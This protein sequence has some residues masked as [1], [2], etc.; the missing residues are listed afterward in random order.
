M[1]FTSYRHFK[2]FRTKLLFCL[3]FGCLQISVIRIIY[4]YFQ[5]KGGSPSHNIFKKC[6]P[7]IPDEGHHSP[8]LEERQRP[9]LGKNLSDGHDRTELE[10]SLYFK[11]EARKKLYVWEND[12]FVPTKR[13]V[14]T[15]GM[16]LLARQDCQNMTNNTP[17]KIEQ[18]DIE[19]STDKH[20][21]FEYIN[22]YAFKEELDMPI[23]YS[24]LVY[25]DYEMLE[26][27]LRTIYKPHNTYCIH[28]DTNSPI[29]YKQ[30][31][32]KL[33][34]GFKN[35]FVANKLYSIKWGTFSIVQ[36]EISCME[37]LLNKSRSWK[38]FIN[39][40]GQEFPLR[41]NYE[42]A[43][44]L[45][46]LRGFNIIRCT[47]DYKKLTLQ[48]AGP[49]PFGLTAFKSSTHVVLT[50]EFV[51]Y[52]L[53]DKQ[54]RRVIYWSKK[55][56][57]PDERVFA[58]LLCNKKL[59]APESFSKTY[60]GL[61]HQNQTSITRYKLWNS[62]K[63]CH[64]KIVRGVCVFGYGDLQTLQKRHELFANKFHINVFPTVPYCLRN[65]LLKRTVLE[66]GDYIDFNV[67]F[68]NNILYKH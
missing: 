26:L 54:A 8:H 65:I 28:V 4:T 29:T 3:V 16:K 48:L 9:S 32:V 19:L 13:S 53:T 44:I 34:L 1:L 37:E 7:A 59:K 67:T 31:V 30:Q 36:A 55:A 46:A 23:A 64:G 6:L 41:T 25:T 24:I 35:V 14:M 42:I 21:E 52:M 10:T 45:H 60:P 66:Y 20:P 12:R 50:R 56:T 51:Q 49:P 2:G 63:K 17:F 18:K 27:L 57:I 61:F 62:V 47:K 68:Y 33:T 43:R 22:L 58:T 5:W 11:P 39:L 40:T 38:Y 15:K